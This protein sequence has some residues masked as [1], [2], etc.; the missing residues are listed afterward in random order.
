MDAFSLFPGGQAYWTMY[1][2][3]LFHLVVVT[4]AGDAG[5]SFLEP[6]SFG[7][8]CDVEVAK[9]VCFSR[10]ENMLLR[11]LLDTRL[12]SKSMSNATHPNRKTISALEGAFDR[13]PPPPGPP[14]PPPPGLLGPP[15]PV[16]EAEDEG[17]WSLKETRGFQTWSF[18]PPFPEVG[19]SEGDWT[20]GLP[21]ES[22]G[23]A[24]AVIDRKCD[25]AMA[26]SVSK[27]SAGGSAARPLSNCTLTAALTQAVVQQIGKT[28]RR[29]GL[30]DVA[31][32]L[33]SGGKHLCDI[34]IEAKVIPTG[35][36]SI[37]PKDCTVMKALTQSV[38]TRV[39]LSLAAMD[40]DAGRVALRPVD[41]APLE[42]SPLTGHSD[43]A[44]PECGEQ[45]AGDGRVDQ[46]E[47][48]EVC[49]SG[50]DTLHEHGTQEHL[51]RTGDFDEH[52]DNDHH[53]ATSDSDHPELDEVERHGYALPADDRQ[54][55]GDHDDLSNH[56]AGQDDHNPSLDDYLNY[57]DHHRDGLSSFDHGHHL[58][59]DIHTARN[60]YS[61]PLQG[62]TAHFDCTGGNNHRSVDKHVAI[63]AREPYH[64]STETSTTTSI[65]SH[66]MAGHLPRKT[67]L[68]GTG[69]E[70]EGDGGLGRAHAHAPEFSHGL[71]SFHLPIDMG[72]GGGRAMGGAM[73]G[74][75]SNRGRS[76]GKTGPAGDPTGG[77]HSGMGKAAGESSMGTGRSSDG[78]SA[79]EGA[80][81][82]GKAM[83][84]S[85]PT[86]GPSGG[87]AGKGKGKG[88]GRGKGNGN[89]KGK[90]QPS[91]DGGGK[92]GK[93]GWSSHAAQR[94][95]S[96]VAQKPGSWM[97]NA[98][99]GLR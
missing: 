46:D 91:S 99:S 81:G 55:V 63:D 27:H 19:P 30:T 2:V 43:R 97:T 65:R 8:A 47:R 93:M 56:Q 35:M 70:L 42:P 89:G 7:R 45:A 74:G 25:E 53:E 80:S 14:P 33:C 15:P 38:Q 87:P 88:N 32:K 17:A 16:W 20:Q 18:F 72:K 48:S 26:A 60:A 90:G 76:M 3:W 39:A 10:S 31:R 67:A 37:E 36:C 64:S 94:A 44:E 11:A 85:K 12:I 66:R 73:G 13:S 68:S 34:L 61:D 51:L 28:N 58:G 41:R 40:K 79:G 77:V 24:K 52:E 71:D 5:Q 95:R 9:A 83:G 86:A 62:H 69:H 98:L 49:T 82:G 21:G 78:K 23:A 4:A 75:L 22:R 54:H 1:L 57:D 6:T 96:D 84:K 59:S 92:M 29:A 50:H